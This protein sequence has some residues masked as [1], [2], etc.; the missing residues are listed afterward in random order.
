MLETLR[1]NI[2]MFLN[3][4]KTLVTIVI[5][6]VP[7][8]NLNHIFLLSSGLALPIGSLIKGCVPMKYSNCIVP[9]IL[10]ILCII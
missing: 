5:K 4:P 9:I 8:L 10:M 1:H 2:P 6:R 7:V 3:L